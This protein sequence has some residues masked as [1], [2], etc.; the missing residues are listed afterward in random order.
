MKKLFAFL[1]IV[2]LSFT[3]FDEPIWCGPEEPDG[4]RMCYHGCAPTCVPVPHCN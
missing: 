1:L 3:V 2:A 4:C